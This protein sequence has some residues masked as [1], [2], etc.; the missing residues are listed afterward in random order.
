M[1]NSGSQVAKVVRSGGPVRPLFEAA[2]EE[3]P[4]IPSLREMQGIPGRDVAGFVLAVATVFKPDNNF[5]RF[6]GITPSLTV[7]GLDRIVKFVRRDSGSTSDMG[8]EVRVLDITDLTAQG[9]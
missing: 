6:A 4:E 2:R 1:K 8:P 5:P 9:V 7:P 3:N